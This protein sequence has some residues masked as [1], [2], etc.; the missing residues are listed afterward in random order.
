MARYAWSYNRFGS[1]PYAIVKGNGL[2]DEVERG[3][4]VIVITAEQQGTLRNAHMASDSDVVQVIDPDILTD[5]NMITNNQPP[6]V[7][8]GH[9]RFDN[10]AFANF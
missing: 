4:F 9:T 10:Y 1:D 3:F 7:F 2:R 8:N 6:R 5:P